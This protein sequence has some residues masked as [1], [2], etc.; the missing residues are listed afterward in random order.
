MI[1][2]KAGEICDIQPIEGENYHDCNFP[3]GGHWITEV[4]DSQCFR[5]KGNKTWWDSEGFKITKTSC[6]PII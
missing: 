1:K 2:L 6:G 3:F 4:D 5:I